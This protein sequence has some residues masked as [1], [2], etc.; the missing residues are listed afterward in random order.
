VIWRLALR[1][2]AVRPWRTLSLLVGYAIGVGVMIVLLSIGD[3]MM[4]QGRDERLVGGGTVTVL[5][6]GLDLEVLKT[7]GLGGMYFSIPNARFVH[8]QILTSPRLGDTV[9]AVAPQIEGK[10]LYLRLANGELVTARATGEIPSLS[11]A[12]D[13][14]PTLTAGVW[15]DDEDDRAWRAPTPRER[16]AVMDHFH[17]T[18]ASAE[19]RSTWAEWHYFNVRTPDA[20]RWA[21]L[22]YALVGDV[23]AG[24]WRGELS[25]TWHETGREARRFAMAVPRTAVRYSTRDADLV[26]GASTVTVDDAGRYRVV[27]NAREIGGAG[28]RAVV[29]LLVT[30]EPRAYFPNAAIGGDGV[31]SGYAVPVLRGT[32]TGSI[33][34]DTRCTAFDA[35]PAYHDHNWGTWRAIAWE[36]GVVQ[37]GALGLL[38]GRVERTDSLAVDEP[39]FVYLTDSLGFRALFRPRVISYDDT[40]RVMVGAVP[41]LVPSRATLFDVRGADTITITLDVEDAMVTDIRDRQRGAT[42]AVRPPRPYFVQ[43]KG[44]ATLRGR[45]GGA[46]FDAS[47]VVFFETYR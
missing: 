2:L 25:L 14:A 28:A 8:A 38:Y 41:V 19:D 11:A 40:R 43:L 4:A 33:C 31:L 24:D 7:G 45:V 3:A 36:W 26:L 12:V 32:V 21:F 10:L 37:A 18:P 5:P 46:P 44:R 15:E 1:T 27:A 22:T 39:L 30:P 13:A 34:I 16:L 6:D 17:E 35:A 29:E 47:G 23:P 42:D 9:T 20:D